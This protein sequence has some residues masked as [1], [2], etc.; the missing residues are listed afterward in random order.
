[1]RRCGDRRIVFAIIDLTNDFDSFLVSFFISIFNFSVNFV[2][3]FLFRFGH[4]RLSCGVP[5][6]Q[7][8][9]AIASRC[10]GL[11]QQVGIHC[12]GGVGGW[13]D[14]HAHTERVVA[15]R[16]VVEGAKLANA[17]GAVRANGKRPESTEIL[18]SVAAGFC[19]GSEFGDVGFG[20]SGEEKQLVEIAHA[21]LFGFAGG[22]SG[23]LYQ[24]TRREAAKRDGCDAE[25]SGKFLQG[26]GGGGL[27]LGDGDTGEAPE[28]NGATGFEMEIVFREIDAAT[29]FSD[30]GIA[31]AEAAARLI[32][33]CPGSAGEPDAG[34]L[35]F[36]EPF[37]EV[38][39][40][41]KD[42]ATSREKRVESDVNGLCAAKGRHD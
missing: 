16:A 13:R 41:M 33:L 2:L 17:F 20:G 25:I 6:R 9:S 21:N 18:Q 12:L 4:F 39:E 10:Q 22:Q 32:E 15:Q 27:R 26:F 42:S 34:K 31:V 36:V 28:A 5:F 38:A 14:C 8:E 24:F 30:E 40:T 1:M 11:E 37:Q 3:A 29:A 19:C 23:V 35:G 7:E